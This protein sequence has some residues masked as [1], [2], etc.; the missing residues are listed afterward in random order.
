MSDQA[1]AL[2]EKG[3]SALNEGKFW[4]AIKYYS[5]A[6]E[7]D[8]DNHVL[9]S[10]RSAAHAKAGNYADALKDGEKTVELKSDWGKGYSRKGAALAYLQR[11][12]EAIACYETGISCDPNNAQLRQGLDEA[13]EAKN[14]QNAGPAPNFANPFSDPA[15]LIKLKNDPRTSKW[16]D[17]PEYLALVRELQTNPKALGTKISDPRVMTTLSVLLGMEIADGPEEMDT[18]EAPPRP[19]TPPPPKKET[20]P[21]PDIPEEK[22]AALKEKEAGNVAYKAKNFDKAIEQYK[23]ALELDPTDM[24]Y[25]LNSAA[26]Y[27]EIKKYED[28]VKEC[29]D[30]IELGR[31]NR[32]DFKLIAKAFLRAGNSYKKMGDFRNAKVFYEKSLSEHRTPETRSLLADVEKLIKEQERKAYINPEKSEEEKEK[33]NELFKKGD[34]ATAMKHYTE[35]IARNPEDARLYSNRAACYTKLAAFDLGLKDCDKCLELDPNFIKAWIRKGKILQGMQDAGK[36]MTAY[37]KALDMDP[38]NAEAAE[39]YQQCMSALHSNPEEMRKR[40]M[41]DPEVQA[42]LRDPA[43]RLILEQMQSDPKALQDH[44]K[45]PEIALKI[46]KLLDSG[47]IAIR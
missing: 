14:R 12:D 41:A 46:Q 40:A 43:M 25:K 18:E 19:A 26:V 3:N 44:L 31:E 21:E 47:L 6:I 20:P 4:D 33:G 39:G 13:K 5:Q 17:D 42:I 8:P 27:F 9:F 23:K 45:N 32:A 24:T 7:V 30:A 28:C 38:N 16:M 10:N 11:Y 36:A 35:A 1:N 37:Q 34:Y 29:L 15:I 2:K 22:K